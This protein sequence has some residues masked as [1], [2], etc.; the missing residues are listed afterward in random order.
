[1]HTVHLDALAAGLPHHVGTVVDHKGH[2]IGLLIVL[3]DLRDVASHVGQLRGIGL[4]GAQLDEGCAAVQ[5]LIHHV[6]QR[7]AFAVLRPHHEVRGQVE[8]VAHG[9]V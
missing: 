5:S 9:G 2:G 3:D 7:T 1:V 4:L 6:G 8:A